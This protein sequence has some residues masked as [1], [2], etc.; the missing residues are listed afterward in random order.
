MKNTMSQEELKHLSN[1]EFYQISKNNKELLDKGT[2]TIIPFYDFPR[3]SKYIPGIVPGD[4]IIVTAGTGQGKSRLS[5]KMFIKDTIRF[6]NESGIKVKLFLNSLEESE[7]KVEQT[8][9]S[10]YLFTKYGVKSG[11]F[12][13]TNYN[14]T[15]LSDEQM[16]KVAEATIWCRKNI[17]NRLEVIFETNP[18]AV[19]KKVRNYLRTIGQFYYI[20]KDAAGNVISKTKTK[21]GEQW[22]HYEYS[23][24]TIVLVINDTV[25]ALTGYT[26]TIGTERN[27]LTK[28]EA[29]RKFS[30][31]YLRGLLCKVCKCIGVLIS[32]QIEAKQRV[33]SNFKGQTILEKLKPGLDGILTCKAIQQHATLAFGLFD[34]VRYGTYNYGNYRNLHKLTGAFRSMI[35]LKTRN[36]TLPNDEIP[37]YCDFSRDFVEELPLPSDESLKSYYK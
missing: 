28:Y 5:R 17:F 14:T 26:E 22:N 24:P 29:V 31:Y 15:A 34:P 11:F 35:V 32:Q 25:D 3:L 23:E 36:G 6:A 16:A 4:H 20:K 37:L 30:E 10:D 8:F 9:V 33:E 1:S 2:P 12:E 18:F 7:A 21:D 27:K 13:L 19:Y